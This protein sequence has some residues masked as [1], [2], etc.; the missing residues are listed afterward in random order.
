MRVITDNAPVWYD[1]ESNPP[2][3]GCKLHL[4]TTGWV[5]VHGEWNDEIYLAWAPL[6]KVPQALKD[7]IHANQRPSAEGVAGA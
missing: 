4:L 5:A 3:R 7:K 1:P 6:P 2:P